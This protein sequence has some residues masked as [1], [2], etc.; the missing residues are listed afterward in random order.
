[1]HN[2]KFFTLFMHFL[3]KI[4]II[5]PAIFWLMMLYA[6]DE[7]LAATLTL[8]AAVIHEAGHQLYIFLALGRVGNMRSTLCGFRISK[9]CILSYK[10]EAL[11]YFSGPLAN[12]FMSIL[13]IPFFFVVNKSLFVYLQ[14]F[15]IINLATAASNLLP[16]KGYDGY[17]ILECVFSYYGIRDAAMRILSVVSLLLSAFICI[18]SL[19]IMARIGDGYWIFG[20]FI[21][22][23][24]SGTSK[25]LAE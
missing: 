6:F 18:L 8:L 22:S 12:I 25:E 3:Q 20:I 23:L 9:G 2:N 11:V 5:L 13:T 17:G 16:I 10:S 19:Y 1:M 4:G 21:F 15:S 7:P 14:L 24:I